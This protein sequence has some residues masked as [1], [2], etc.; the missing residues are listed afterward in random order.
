MNPFITKLAFAIGIML[1]TIPAY[2]QTVTLTNGPPNLPA[3]TIQAGMLSGSPVADV[4]ADT[5]GNTPFTGTFNQPTGANAT[6]FSISTATNCGSA[7]NITCGKLA[8]NGVLGAGTYNITLTTSQGGSQNVA[9]NAVSGTAIGCGSSTTI[10]NAINSAG[11]NTTFLL[12][13]C[14][15]SI[16]SAL[17][18]KSGD[19][20]IGITGS[21][22][23]DCLGASVASIDTNGAQGGAAAPNVTV[24]NLTVQ[25]CGVRGSPNAINAGDG[26]TMTNSTIINNNASV[27]ISGGNITFTN[28]VIGHNIENNVHGN[29]NSSNPIAFIGNEFYAANYSQLDTCDNAGNFKTFN[30]T[31]LTFNYNYVHDNIGAGIWLD[32]VAN[33]NTTITGNTFINNGNGGIQLEDSTGTV[34]VGFNIL[35]GNGNGDVYS[36]FTCAGGV[37]AN[38]SWADIW[39][40]GSRGNISIHDNN[41]SARM[42]MSSGYPDT[43]MLLNDA[44]GRAPDLNGISFLS[45]TVRFKT[46]NTNACW[47][48]CQGLSNSGI[49]H[50]G[51]SSNGDQFHVPS[52]STGDA[53]FSWFNSPGSIVSFSSLQTGG[54]Q[55]ASGSINTT[56]TTANG[57]LHVACAANPVG[58]GGIQQVALAIQNITLSNSTFTPNIANGTVGTVSVTMSDGSVF[59]GKLSITGTNSGGFHLSGNTLEEKASGTS[60]GTYRDFNIVAAQSTASNSPQQISPTVTGVVGAPFGGTARSMTNRIQTEDFDVGGYGVAYHTTDACGIGI[61][62]AYG[63]DR[64]NVYP[65]ADLDGASNLKVGC[66]QVGDWYNY[67]ITAATTGSYTL[68]LRGANIEAGATYHVAIDGAIVVKGIAVPNTGGYD[69]FATVTSAPFGLTAGQHVMQIA[70]DAAG[71]SGFGGDFNWVQGTLVAAGAIG[72]KNVDITVTH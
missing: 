14:S 15:Y 13:A 46:A 17:A 39:E 19:A 59:S 16:S 64:I 42:G 41:I 28:N 56:D 50:S 63:S 61:D 32:T 70:L 40:H 51:S 36:A 69:T 45:N 26:F 52:G 55:E 67:T 12:G 30:F 22:V 11:T 10:Q 57:C 21:T 8:T 27:A 5:P 24:R 47:G 68:N 54:G 38:Q 9:I 49:S 3:A 48:V 35:M 66:Y 2:A 34:D 25:G 53:H 6:S 65:T 23:W 7:R 72:T 58:P 4:Y 1:F 62:T 20:F 18:P 31:P 44:E 71:P 60:A 29:A 43:P 37:S 33:G